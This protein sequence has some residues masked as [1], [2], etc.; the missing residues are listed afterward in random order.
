[1]QK[2]GGG[3]GA[4]HGLWALLTEGGKEG[5]TEE[6]KEEEGRSGGECGV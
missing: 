1:M 2:H 6:E 4:N 5:E 3:G